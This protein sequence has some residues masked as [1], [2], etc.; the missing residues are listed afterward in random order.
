MSAV[1]NNLLPFNKI[2]GTSDIFTD[3]PEDV[4]PLSKCQDLRAI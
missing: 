4:F 2:D 3:F 1:K